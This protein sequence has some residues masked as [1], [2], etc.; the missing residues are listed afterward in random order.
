MTLLPQQDVPPKRI[1]LNS[2]LAK[3]GAASLLVGAPVA[4]AL[5][6]TG[7][8]AGGLALI[9]L[10]LI[11]AA[12]A[13]ALASRLSC[14][15]R[16][17]SPEQKIGNIIFAP[18]VN[19]N[20]NNI[21]FAP[22]IHQHQETHIKQKV[23]STAPPAPVAASI[24]M[25]TV[26]ARAGLEG[27]GPAETFTGHYP[28]REWKKCFQAERVRQKTQEHRDVSSHCDVFP[29]AIGAPGVTLGYYET[30]SAPRWTW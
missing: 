14:G 11:G 29:G 10:S 3:I 20:G 26:K 6:A 1:S 12:T 21:T 17:N 25:V 2:V 9:G 13:G 7:L 23:V 8:V 16:V 19:G 28:A 27:L 30:K 18:V 22:T 5:G 24:P 15:S 4:I